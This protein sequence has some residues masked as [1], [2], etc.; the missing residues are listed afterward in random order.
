MRVPIYLTFLLVFAL[1]AI[2]WRNH[3]RTQTLLNEREK[4]TARARADGWL[5]DRRSGYGLSKTVLSRRPDEIQIAREATAALIAYARE[6]PFPEGFPADEKQR[7]VARESERILSL[8]GKQLKIVIDELRAAT[9]IDTRFRSSFIEFALR[10]LLKSN[11]QDA[12]KISL[13][14]KLQTYKGDFALELFETWSGMDAGQAKE[15]LDAHQEKLGEAANRYDWALIN[16]AVMEDPLMAMHLVSENKPESG[17]LSL[18]RSPKLSPEQRLAF[19]SAFRSWQKTPAGKTMIFD[20]RT[21][22]LSTLIFDKSRSD[23][24]PFAEISEF[25]ETA[26][27]DAEEIREISHHDISS[28]IAPED[29]V[30]LYQWIGKTLAEEDAARW[31]SMLERS[32][33]TSTPIGEWLARQPGET[34]KTPPEGSAP[35]A[36]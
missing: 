30:E 3:H 14:A 34:G 9:E 21:S 29:A 24:V 36:D 26:R 5:L 19:L 6:L 20:D 4:L 33:D 2:G 16:G 13:D 1:G 7:R 10:A 22:V 18:V 25:W 28:R 31:Q 15:W 12:L 8:N 11:P 32:S 17:V 27:L 35:F 23:K